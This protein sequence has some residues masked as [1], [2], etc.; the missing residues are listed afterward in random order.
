MDAPPKSLKWKARAKL[1]RRVTPA[2]VS[3]T[4]DRADGAIIGGALKNDTG[5]F[6]PVDAARARAFRA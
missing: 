6:T 3:L 5:Y 1:G 4:R 2:T